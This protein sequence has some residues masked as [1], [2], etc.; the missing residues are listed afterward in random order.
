MVSTRA[1]LPADDFV[2]VEGVTFEDLEDQYKS[3]KMARE[4]E[5]LNQT[6]S[7]PSD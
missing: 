1:P 6:G 4:M 3:Q 2:R 7:R 5:K